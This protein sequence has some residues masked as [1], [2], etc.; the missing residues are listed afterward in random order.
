MVS[1]FVLLSTVLFL[2]S[3]CASTQL[4]YNTMDLASTTDDLLQRQVL[5]NLERFIDSD[6]AIPAQIVI[7]SGAASTTNSLTPSISAP[8][9]NSVVQSVTPGKGVT[10]S[11]LTRPAITGSLSASDTWSQNWGFAP[12]NDVYQ[13]R[14]LS[15]LYRYAIDGDAA[16]FV[17]NYPPLFKSINITR[18]DCLR[19]ADGRVMI[20]IKKTTA[21]SGNQRDVTLCATATGQ[22]GANGLSAGA[23]TVSDVELVPDEHYLKGPACA[24]C[25]RRH[26]SK[27]RLVPNERLQPAW[28]RWRNLPGAGSRPERPPLP[29][30]QPL[31]TFGHHELFAAQGQGSKFAEFTLFVL[32]ASTQTDATSA[33]NSTSSAGG[34]KGNKPGTQSLITPQGDVIPV[35]PSN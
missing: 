15:A 29:G 16:A 31:G 11:Q 18:P 12:I 26:S 4:N 25:M 20:T 10:G 9:A 19:D 33:S 35:V 7:T 1:R 28:L 32:A 17:Q 5:H 34:G 13:M 23:T 27:T 3:G 2:I 30:D 21:S 6:A 14:R 8:F 24:V 22:S